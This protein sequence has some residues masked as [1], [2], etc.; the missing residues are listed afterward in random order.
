MTD[1]DLARITGNSDPLQA[2][3]ETTALRRRLEGHEEVLVHR[4]RVSGTTWTQIAEA[5]GVSKQAVHKKYGGRRLFGRS[6]A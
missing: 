5:L 4:A 1:V 6:E 2:L 3:R